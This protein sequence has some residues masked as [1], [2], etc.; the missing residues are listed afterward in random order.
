MRLLVSR[1]CHM[2]EVADARIDSILGP[3]ALVW[4]IDALLHIERTH[5]LPTQMES[6]MRVKVRRRLSLRS[7]A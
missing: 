6:A 7:S 5:T 1:D 3:E 2:R 4:K